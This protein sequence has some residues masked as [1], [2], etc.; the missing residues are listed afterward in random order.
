MD[1]RIRKYFCRIGLLCAERLGERFR[2]R[3]LRVDDVEK[4]GVAASREVFGMHAS[5]PSCTEERE[6]NHR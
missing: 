3:R 4:L 5:D 1:L 6:I 2:C